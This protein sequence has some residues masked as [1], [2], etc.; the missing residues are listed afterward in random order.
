V[1]EKAGALLETKAAKIE[2]PALRDAF[3]NRVAVHREVQALVDRE[4]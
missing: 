2:D 4:L 1:L 3:L